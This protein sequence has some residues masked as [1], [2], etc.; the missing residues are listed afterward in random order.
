MHPN[1][2]QKRSCRKI[3][4]RKKGVPD[5]AVLLVICGA[6]ILSVIFIAVLVF[7]SPS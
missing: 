4:D 2:D 3:R 5:Y 1:K 6:I 7:T